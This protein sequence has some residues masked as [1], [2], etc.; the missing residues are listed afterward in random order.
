MSQI[1]CHS[2]GAIQNEKKMNGRYKSIEQSTLTVRNLVRL[3]I[4]HAESNTDYFLFRLLYL[5][6]NISN[7]MTFCTKCYLQGHYK[8][9]SLHRRYL[10]SPFKLRWRGSPAGCSE[11]YEEHCLV[12]CMEE[13]RNSSLYLAMLFNKLKIIRSKCANLINWTASLHSF[14]SCFRAVTDVTNF[15]F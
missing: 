9:K 4:N 6:T 14:L 11:I 3:L 10:Y 5:P 7:F 13:F 8:T 15:L 1:W 2:S 12:V